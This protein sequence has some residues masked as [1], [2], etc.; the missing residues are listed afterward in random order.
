MP[1]RPRKKP[2]SPALVAMP[3][4]AALDGIPQNAVDRFRPEGDVA[5]MRENF[6]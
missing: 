6:Y 4:L 2:S 1:R 5:M 3:Q